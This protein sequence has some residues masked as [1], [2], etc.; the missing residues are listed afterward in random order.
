MLTPRR[1]KPLPPPSPPPSSTCA[2]CSWR[3]PLHAPFAIALR[4][5]GRSFNDCHRL[6]PNAL[7][8]ARA[9]GGL[10]A[11]F[12]GRARACSRSERVPEAARDHRLDRRHRAAGL[13]PIGRGWPI[14]GHA[15]RDSTTAPA[16]ELEARAVPRGK[17]PEQP[18]RLDVHA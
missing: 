10:S 13:L 1:S 5:L 2:S 7:E 9:R 18:H 16:L 15:A 17:R 11:A 14:A 8:N 3:S 12:T 4:V 6:T